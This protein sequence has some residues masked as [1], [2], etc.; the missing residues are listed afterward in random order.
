[1]HY[2][3]A[4]FSKNGLATIQPKQSGIKLLYAYER[5]SLSKIDAQEIRKYYNCA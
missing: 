3:P 1:M 5:N 2:G 4:E